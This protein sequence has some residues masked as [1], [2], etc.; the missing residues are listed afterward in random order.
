MRKVTEE[1]LAK[2]RKNGIPPYFRYSSKEATRR[3]NE[4]YWS[5]KNLKDKNLTNKINSLKNEGFYNEEFLDVIE[6]I[7]EYD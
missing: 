2:D 4:D 1:Q 5:K 6:R 7:R 3:Q